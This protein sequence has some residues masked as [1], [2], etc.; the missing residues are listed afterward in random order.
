[1][2][3]DRVHGCGVLPKMRRGL[4]ALGL[5]RVALMDEHSDPAAQ[6]E[7]NRGKDKSEECKAH[8]RSPLKTRLAS[9]CKARPAKSQMSMPIATSAAFIPRAPSPSGEK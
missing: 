4:P 7:R 6:S 5:G 1:M 2:L 8:S 9:K 3:P